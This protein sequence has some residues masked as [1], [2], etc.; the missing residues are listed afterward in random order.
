MPWSNPRAV[1]PEEAYVAAI[2]SC[3]MLTFLFVAAARRMREGVYTEEIDV[4]SSDELGEL[5]GSFNAMQHAI[6]DREREREELIIAGRDLGELGE[7]E[8]Q[9]ADQ[10]AAQ[11]RSIVARAR[12]IVAVDHAGNVAHRR[13]CRWRPRSGVCSGRLGDPLCGR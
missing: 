4:R 2:S 5:A 9:L 11:R 7:L 6:A 13:V 12:V 8:V 3:H 10:I 1:D